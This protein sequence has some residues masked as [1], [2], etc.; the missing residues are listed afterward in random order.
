[1]VA[2]FP[3]QFHGRAMAFYPR[4]VIVAAIE[5]DRITIIIIIQFI[6]ALVEN[7]GAESEAELPS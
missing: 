6:T 5:P 2:D 1:M 7:I 3:V 4:G